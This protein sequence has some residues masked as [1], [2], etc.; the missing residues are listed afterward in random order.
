[1]FHFLMQCPAYNT[2]RRALR[3]RAPTIAGRIARLLTPGTYSIHL[4]Q[5]IRKTRRFRAGAATTNGRDG[6]SEDG[7]AGADAL[8]M[9]QRD[10]LRTGHELWI[11]MG[12]ALLETHGEGNR[13]GM[14]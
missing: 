13:E 2:A 11:R 10:A 3:Q 6:G 4:L 8:R 9:R 5:Y 14:G 1:V 12:W 7:E